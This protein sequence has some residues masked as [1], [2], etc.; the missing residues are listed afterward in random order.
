MVF[1]CYS[2][3]IGLPSVVN[4]FYLLRSCSFYTHPTQRG[5]VPVYESGA[6]RFEINCDISSAERH[7]GH[8]SRLR[9]A[10][11][12]TASKTKYSAALAVARKYNRS[13]SNFY[14]RSISSPIISRWYAKVSGVPQLAHLEDTD[15][16]QLLL[17]LGK[18]L[19]ESSARRWNI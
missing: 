9:T 6:V 14:L 2:C 15:L 16:G 13:A 3:Q 18:Q 10:S 12:N 1:W 5:V 11:R 17:Q 4:C 7:C 8:S 19:S